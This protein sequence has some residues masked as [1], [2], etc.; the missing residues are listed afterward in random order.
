MKLTE[1]FKELVPETLNFNV[2]YFE[3]QSH[4]KIWLVTREDFLTM[5]R[6]YSKGEVT[7]WCDSRAAEEEEE[8]GCRKKR[9]R[10]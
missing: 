4:S 7:L 6:K 1:E 9:K 10:D 5:Y 3:G 8:L 2:G